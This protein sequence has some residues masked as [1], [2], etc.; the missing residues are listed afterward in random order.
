MPI[1][2]AEVGTPYRCPRRLPQQNLPI[3]GKQVGYNMS[4]RPCRVEID[5]LCDQR[6]FLPFHPRAIHLRPTKEAPQLG[7]PNFG[8]SAASIGFAA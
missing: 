3:V 8:R 6:G 4:A 2:D 7:S 1:P 5:L